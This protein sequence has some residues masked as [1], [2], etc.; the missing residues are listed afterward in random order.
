MSFWDLAKRF[1]M[2]QEGNFAVIL[3]V[4]APLLLIAAATGIDVFAQ[5]NQSSALQNVADG[6][7]LAAVRE[8]GL[9][10]WSERTAASVAESYVKANIHG[11]LSKTSGHKVETKI[12][13]LKR[14]VAVTITQRF[15]SL[16]MSRVVSS[17]QISVQAVATS[18]GQANICIIV[19]SSN[20]PEAFR[21]RGSGTIRALDCA[22][23]SNSLDPIGLVAKRKSRLLTAMSCSAGGYSGSRRNYNPIP[24]TDCPQ[25]DDPLVARAEIIDST[26]GKMR[27][28]HKDFVLEATKKILY[29]GVYCG[30]TTLTGGSIAFMRSGIYVFKGKLR[31]DGKSTLIGRGVGFV[32]AGNRSKLNFKHESTIALTAPETGPM[33]GILIYAQ[34]ASRKGEFKIES[35]DAKQLVGTVYLPFDTLKIG[36]DDNDDGICDIELETGAQ[37]NTPDS[38]V[39]DGAVTD[40]CETSVGNISAWTAIVVDKLKITNGVE[41][42]INTD[43]GS[44]TIPVPEG[45]GP[46]QGQTMLVR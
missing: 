33:A 26:V 21:L 10:G 5:R 16:F 34:R 19:K 1:A 18:V 44:S 32:F 41:V 31:L 25:I 3:A 14:S 8:A 9:R 27:C 2:S 42:T 11:G 46:V 22:A 43:Y 7:A 6:A 29:P 36:A 17:S 24:L 45:L 35:N 28:D 23:Y 40:L 38:L 4:C 30:D 12:D 39:I 13:K 20:E 37:P 15:A